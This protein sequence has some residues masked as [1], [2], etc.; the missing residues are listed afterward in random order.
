MNKLNST[1]SRVFDNPTIEMI[2]DQSKYRNKVLGTGVGVYCD[3]VWCTCTQM[4]MC[5]CVWCGCV[6]VCICECISVAKIITICYVYIAI[7]SSVCC[8][9]A[10]EI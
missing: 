6:G 8:V 9:P 7:P 3:N 1:S 4:Y 2:W 10:N 5:G